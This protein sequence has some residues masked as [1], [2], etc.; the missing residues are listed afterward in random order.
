MFPRN[1]TSLLCR[2]RKRKSCCHV[3]AISQAGVAA[4]NQ[5]LMQG[6]E[7][8]KKNGSCITFPTPVLRVY[9]A[10]LC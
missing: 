8:K 4:P 3:I 10:N 9:S 7:G 2:F 6:F 5:T 1:G